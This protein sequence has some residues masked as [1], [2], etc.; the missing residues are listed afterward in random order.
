M[1]EIV[2]LSSAGRDIHHVSLSNI[3]H[4]WIRHE[5]IETL[6][7][8]IEI[9]SIVSNLFKRNAKYQWRMERE[10]CMYNICI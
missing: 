4:A 1:S 6:L 3:D 9:G 2:S 8:Y 5:Y 10:L 7:I